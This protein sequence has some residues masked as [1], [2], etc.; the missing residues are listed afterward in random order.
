MDKKKKGMAPPVLAVCQQVLE[1]LTKEFDGLAPD[2][3]ILEKLPN[4]DFFVEKPLGFGDIQRQL[5]TYSLASFVKGMRRIAAN[6]LRYAQDTEDRQ[7]AQKYLQRFEHLMAEE[8]SNIAEFQPL[9]DRSPQ[10]VT[11]FAILNSWRRQVRKARLNGS[12]C[13]QRIEKAFDPDEF[14]TYRSRIRR[15]FD[16][17][18][19]VT[20]LVENGCSAVEFLEYLDLSLHNMK[21]YWGFDGGESGSAYVTLAERFLKFLSKAAIAN[22]PDE[23][24]ELQKIKGSS[25]REGLQ[26]SKASKK[27]GFSGEDESTDQARYLDLFV[28]FDCFI[29]E[30]SLT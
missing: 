13:F 2:A 15:P 9:K 19:A 23:W 4:Y 25:E 1:Q 26:K 10:Y 6:G 28:Y 29:F 24:S 30:T 27:A 22:L 5:E 12:I 20:A 7:R 8:G 16:F 14:A 3:A 18:K 17:G 21:E 11:C